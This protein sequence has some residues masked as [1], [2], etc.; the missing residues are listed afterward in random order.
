M[1][2]PLVER[3]GPRKTDDAPVPLHLAAAGQTRPGEVKTAAAARRTLARLAA[4]HADELWQS[5][6]ARFPQQTGSAV[7]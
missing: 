4:A 5:G 6:R 7:I 2:N 1:T 3:S